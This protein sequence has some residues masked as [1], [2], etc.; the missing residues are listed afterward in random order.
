MATNWLYPLRSGNG[1]VFLQKNLLTSFCHETGI[2]QLAA[3]GRLKI[4]RFRSSKD[5]KWALQVEKHP[6]INTAVGAEKN[7]FTLAL[8]RSPVEEG[9]QIILRTVHPDEDPALGL[10]TFELALQYVPDDE[11]IS[12]TQNAGP[13]NKNENHD[14]KLLCSYFNVFSSLDCNSYCMLFN[15]QL[16]TCHKVITQKTLTSEAKKKKNLGC[17]CSSL[18]GCVTSVDLQ[19]VMGD[20]DFPLLHEVRNS[21]IRSPGKQ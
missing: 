12:I 21:E 2:Q 8:W 5:S 14:L 4:N 19:I 11:Q 13:S 16:F 15:N 17:S 7:L 1:F 10:G 9:E 3:S 6:K 20:L 18:T